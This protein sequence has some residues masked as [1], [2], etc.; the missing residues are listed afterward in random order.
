MN[1]ERER[2]RERRIRSALGQPYV[3]FIYNLV[4]AESYLGMRVR[5]RRWQEEQHRRIGATQGTLS[6][7]VSAWGAGR[8][9]EGGR[10]EWKGEGGMEGEGGMRG[11]ERE[12]E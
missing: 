4:S 5:R 10:D 7:R 6:P 12:R 3:L 8:G 2:E 9:I 11:R 1:G